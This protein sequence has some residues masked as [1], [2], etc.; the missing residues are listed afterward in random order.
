MLEFMNGVRS[1]RRFEFAALLLLGFMLGAEVSQAENP[2]EA[3]AKSEK[4]DIVWYTSL[5]VTTSRP[6]ADL[7]QKRYPFLK[8]S[9]YR[10]S[11]ERILN[12]VLTEE[13]AGG[14][15]F[16]VVSS[17]ASFY[18]KKVGLLSPYASPEM[19]HYADGLVDPE[20]YWTSFFSNRF[21]IGY[22]TE[23]VPKEHAPRDWPDLLH[24]RWRG[25]IGIDTEEFLWYG[26]MVKYLGEEKAR[27]FM[28]RLARQ[29]IQWRK[30]HTLIAQMMAV[31]EFPVAIIYTHRIDDMSS[32]GAPVTWVR[33]AD[34]IVLGVSGIGVSAKSRA[35]ASSRLFIDF[36]LSHEAQLMIT[37]S[38]RNSGRKD[39]QGNDVGLKTFAIPEEVLTDVNHYAEDFNKLFHAGS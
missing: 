11:A 36:A 3:K 24:P 19:V 16:D 2:W 23:L 22:N 4:G 37:K 31:G 17:Q 15:S 9:V 35:P 13:K 32:K 27:S 38:G 28:T 5:N 30:G 1:I 8:V 20:K 6:I 34:P 26:A 39:L 18:F 10:S 7:F 29:D 14:S 21:A 33:T 12:K 25:K